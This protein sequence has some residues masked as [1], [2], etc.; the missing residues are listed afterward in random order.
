MD[1]GV[2]DVCGNEIRRPDGYLLTT[3]QVVSRPAYWVYAFSHQWSYVDALPRAEEVRGALA[4]QQAGQRTPWL[5]CRDC[6]QRLDADLSETKHHAEQWWASDGHFAPP[7]SGAVPASAVQ[8]APKLDKA[9]ASDVPRP[10]QVYVFGRSFRPSAQQAK[11]AL[12]GI[13][14][15]HKD[16]LTPS[17]FAGV[18]VHVESEA[19]EN[20]STF[21]LVVDRVRRQH[22]NACVVDCFRLDQRTQQDMVA[23]AVWDEI[24]AR[25]AERLLQKQAEQDVVTTT[26]TPTAQ[27]AAAVPSPSPREPEQDR[28]TRKWWQFRRSMR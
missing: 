13:L 27:A 3:R 6:A 25:T 1:R 18:P 9:L 7:G 20:R 22:P 10:T 15:R 21:S 2:C 12:G 26:R 14:A 24:A 11:L 8:M 17:H 23:I 5:V 28:N 16:M 4:Q 19:A